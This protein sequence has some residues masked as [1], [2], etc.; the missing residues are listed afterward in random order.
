M[1]FEFCGQARMDS[2]LAK[3]RMRFCKACALS[4]TDEQ[5]NKYIDND[6]PRDR[7]YTSTVA[8]IA[9]FVISRELVSAAQWHTH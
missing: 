3:E 6:V 8:R 5:T 2:S 4:T 1:Q 7:T 9:R